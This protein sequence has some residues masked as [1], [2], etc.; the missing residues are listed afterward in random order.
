VIEAGRYLGIAIAS[1]I[2]LLNP[3]IVM[4]G[5]GV[6]QTGDLLLEPIRQAVRERSLK[7][8]S[9]AMRIPSAVL[10]RR[11]SGIGAIIQA[12][13]WVLHHSSGPLQNSDMLKIRS[14]IR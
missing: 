1:L 14:P 9:Q 6:A 4:I 7:A 3:G 11:S 12:A 13:T 5:G 2:N 8:A 10:G